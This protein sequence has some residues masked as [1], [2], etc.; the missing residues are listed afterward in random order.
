MPL[1]LESLRVLDFSSYIAG[2]YCP[3]LLADL[4]AEVIKI[5]AYCG[6]QT[7]YFPSTLKS[8]TRMFLGVNCNKKGIVLDRKQE[9]AREI[10][11]KLINTGQS[12][13]HGAACHTPG[14]RRHGHAGRAHQL[15]DD[16][17]SSPE[18]RPNTGQAYRGDLAQ[19][20]VYPRPG[21]SAETRQGDIEDFSALPPGGKVE[22]GDEVGLRAPT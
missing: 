6:D 4:G 5:E 9:V 19:S 13:R 10:V 3:A 7:R 14:R 11:Y 22:I 12:P 17:K 20:R 8:E 16:A 2:P 1:P 18:A 15:L 21:G